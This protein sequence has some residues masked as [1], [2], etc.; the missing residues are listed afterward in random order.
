MSSTGARTLISTMYGVYPG[1]WFQTDLTIASG[2][3]P[4]TSDPHGYALD[5]S[6]QHCI[7]FVSGA[8]VLELAWSQIDAL[9]PDA[10]PEVAAIWRRDVLYESFSDAQKPEGRPFG[11]LFA[12]RRGVVFRT[13]DTGLWA[14]VESDE[15]GTWEP[16]RRLDGGGVPGAA[17]DAAGVLVTDGS[18]AAATIRSR[19]IFFIG[20]DGN[21]HHLASDQ[22]GATWSH[23][24]LNATTG[25]PR[26]V[27]DAVPSAYVRRHN[28][29][30][31]LVYRDEKGSIQH[32]S[33]PLADVSAWK[34]EPIT[35]AYE[36]AIDDP[37][38]YAT[39]FGGTHHIVYRAADRQIHELWENTNG[40]HEFVPTELVK[41]SVLASGE[42]FGYALEAAGKQHVIFRTREGGLA[43]LWWDTKGWHVDQFLLVDPGLDPIGPLISPF[44][45]EDQTAAHTFYVE[46]SMAEKTVHDWEEYVV[47][48]KEFVQAYRPAIVDVAP[49]FPNRIKINPS[50]LAVITKPARDSLLDDK[51]LALVTS[52]G[53]FAAE[54]GVRSG[55]PSSDP[56][57]PKLLRIVDTTRG[58]ALDAFTRNLNLTRGRR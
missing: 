32:L 15:A 40:W 11:G 44:F 36:P 14:L 2:A 39:D 54:G 45:Y 26:P 41:A 25:S 43:L 53:L 30:L 8:R 18:T 58:G 38:G 49:H 47:T 46:P 51:T 56:K 13:A 55:G 24:D 7:P 16:P 27:K 50:E 3:E 31:H 19:H 28:E 57:S 21:I 12:P 17:A 48:T 10:D 34:N 52:K 9:G 42:V 23:T 29:R 4:A 20:T 35:V 33:A 37:V 6:F 22:S 1:A 5:E